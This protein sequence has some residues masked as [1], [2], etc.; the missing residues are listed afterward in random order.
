M[1]DLILD[2]TVNAG[3]LEDFIRSEISKIR[4]DSI[5]RLRC[6]NELD[7]AVKSLVTSQLLRRLMPETMNFQFGSEFR[8]PG[9]H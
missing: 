8:Y 3:N 5:V 7:P 4:V 2:G 6:D 1:V 9:S